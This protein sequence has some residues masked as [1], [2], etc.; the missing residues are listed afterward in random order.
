MF[1]RY[2]E[3]TTDAPEEFSSGER[4][5]LTRHEWAGLANK[6]NLADGHARQGQSIAEEAVVADLPAIFCVAEVAEQHD[7]QHQFE[8]AFYANAGQ[9][10][11][12][13]PRPPLLHHYSSSVSTEVV[14]NYLRDQGSRVGLLHPTFDNIAAILRRH[15]IP[16]IPISEQI[17]LNPDDPRL[18]AGWEVLFLVTPNNPTGIDPTPE[19]IRLIADNCAARDRILILDVSFRFFSNWM[20][21][22]DQYAYFDSIGLRYIGIEDTG[23]TWPTLDLKL[24]TLVCDSILQPPLLQIS[25]DFL[26][27]VSPFIFA[28]LKR[29]IDVDQA[30]HCLSAGITNR[31]ILADA[32]RDGP[33][34]LL[35]SDASMSVA[36]LRLP[37]KWQSSEICTWLSGKGISVLPGGPFFWAS[38]ALGQRYIRVALMRPEGKFEEG[39]TALGKALQVYA[40]GKGA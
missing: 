30:R 8:E 32:L 39:A 23:K 35:P 6:F 1:R 19:T 10:S 21:S 17:F 4:T 11:V 16:L 22:W 36:W 24:G 13:R 5:S 33:V 18:Y 28:L 12:L 29:Y 3:P 37:D 34:E 9:L 15:D 27:N 14:A 25:D 31:H 38:P 20:C 2:E 40:P 26:L 7:L